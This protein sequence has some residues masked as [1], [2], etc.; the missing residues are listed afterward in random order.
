[1]IRASTLYNES[2]PLYRV[3]DCFA[4]MG[5]A[6]LAV[7]VLGLMVTWAGFIRGVRWTW[8]VMFVIV[9]G[10]AFPVYMLLYVHYWKHLEVIATFASGIRES[11]LAR[12]F[13]E[14][15]LTFLLMVLALVLPVKTFFG[16]RRG[17]AGRIERRNPGAP[18]KWPR[19][20]TLT[21]SRDPVAVSSILFTL[22]LLI[23]MPAMWR[24]A[25]N[26]PE[27]SLWG[28]SR[29]TEEWPPDCFASAGVC[30]LAVMAIGLIVTWAGY[31]R[32]VRW[33]W[34]VMFVIVCAW[35]FPVLILPYLL[36][37]RGVETMAQSFAS[38]ISRGGVAL[39][40]LLMLL[41]L[42][43]PFKTLVLGRGVPQAGPS[44]RM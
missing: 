20:W 37:R 27:S 13:V 7:I 26:L 8:F 34:F 36:P 22:A 25:A 32:R 3:Y 18:D 44:A 11:G 21:S 35:A 28:F 16:G 2:N 43:L 31:I 33:T 1:L 4:P 24:A 40:F 39:A 38:A 19:R 14:N 10:W 41:A 42:L 15:V 17:S 5:F 23:L 29:T 30:S 9:C 6:S 12:V